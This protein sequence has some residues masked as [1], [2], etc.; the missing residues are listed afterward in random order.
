MLQSTCAFCLLLFSLLVIRAAEPPLIVY[1]H[2]GE[3]GLVFVNNP[4]I[5]LAQ[6]LAENGVAIYRERLAPG[7]WRSWCEHRNAT[8]AGIA[9]GVAIVN[10]GDRPLAVEREAVATGAFGDVFVD[11][12]NAAEPEQLSVPPGGWR[13]LVRG[14]ARKGKFF[15]S[16]VDLRLGAAGVLVHVVAR[17]LE[18]IDPAALR[19]LGYITREHGK[20]HREARVYKGS[21]PHA[22]AA[23]EL[24]YTIDD[25][26]SGVLPARRR[27]FDPETGDYGAPVDCP[28]GWRTNISIGH[29]PD[30]VMSDMFAFQDPGRQEPFDPGKR[31]DAL[32]LFPN[33]G[34]W[35]VVYRHHGS[36]TNVGSRPRRVALRLRGKGLN[37]AYRDADGTWHAVRHGGGS[38]DWYV[39]TVPAG[40]TREFDGRWILG[41]PANGNVVQS[42]VLLPERDAG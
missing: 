30:A 25:D 26:D 7:A 17:D 33:V 35:A 14:Q 10:P 39:F 36:I 37:L 28:N 11:A 16:L 21:N 29:E 23:L 19:Y 20:R 13:W 9:H 32:D 3:R 2:A 31:S 18:A 34:N 1:R 4:E 12:W 42:V 27:P 6:D 24:A 40:A 38:L 8:D 41:G 5:V 15:G 22:M